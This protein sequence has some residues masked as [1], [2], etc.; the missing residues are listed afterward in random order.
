MENKEVNIIL[1]GVDIEKIVVEPPIRSL[2]EGKYSNVVTLQFTCSDDKCQEAL[3]SIDQLDSDFLIAAA[4]AEM[5]HDGTDCWADKCIL[6]FATHSSIQDPKRCVEAT[7][8][9]ELPKITL[10][11]IKSDTLDVDRGT[12]LAAACSSGIMKLTNLLWTDIPRRGFTIEYCQDNCGYFDT[13]ADNS[14][15][16]KFALC[17]LDM[18]SIDMQH[19]IRRFRR[20]VIDANDCGEPE[21]FMMVVSWGDMHDRIGPSIVSMLKILGVESKVLGPSEC[22]Q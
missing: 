4:G 5:R 16:E 10:V 12:R 22:E 19:W 14:I 11:E 17:T 1:H 13:L 8:S 20:E 6:K 15:F 7:Y 3:E 2:T 18:K 9:D 21:K